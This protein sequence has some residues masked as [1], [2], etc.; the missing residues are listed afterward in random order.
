MSNIFGKIFKKSKQSQ[1]STDQTG[2]G[3]WL[4]TKAGKDWEEIGVFV[5]DKL[6]KAK[7]DP[8]SRLI[9]F[10]DGS[11]HSV[12]GAAQDIATELDRDRKAVHEHILSW[13]EEASDPLD[14]DA[15]DEEFADEIQTWIHEEERSN[16]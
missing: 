8:G 10:E 15:D 7:A 2:W 13:L 3:G 9:I 11:Q 16:R 14:D 4:D 1:K 6:E 12:T 5:N